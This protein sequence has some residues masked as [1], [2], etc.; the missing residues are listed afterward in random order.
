M[1]G[2]IFQVPLVPQV[3]QVPQV[4]TVPTV[5]RVPSVPYVPNIGN[6][7]TF[8]NNVNELINLNSYDTKQYVN[9]YDDPTRYRSIAD[10]VRSQPLI[11][12]DSGLINVAEDFGSWFSDN[13]IRNIPII[14]GLL[15]DT[16]DGTVDTVQSLY[17]DIIAIPYVGDV[18]RY[19]E[20][21]TFRFFAGL[22]QRLWNYLDQNYINPTEGTNPFLNA[23][24]ALGKDLDFFTGAN[25]VKSLVIP[26][27]QGDFDIIGNVR[28]GMGSS[29]EGIKHYNWD[30]GIFLLDLALE[31]ISDPS[32][33]ITLGGKSLVID[34]LAE[35][36][37]ESVESVTKTAIQS[38]TGV[39]DEVAEGLVKQ[40][41][42]ATIKGK[43][44]KK[45]LARKISE[46]GLEEAYTEYYSLIIKDVINNTTSEEIS[47]ALARDMV[48]K[49]GQEGGQQ[50]IKLYAMRLALSGELGDTYQELVEQYIE[51]AAREQTRKMFTA[52]V[53]N[54]VYNKT[55]QRF[56]DKGVDIF[57]LVDK[58]NTLKKVTNET[59]PKY[60][61]MTNPLGL[62]G[63]G[64]KKY[65][66][67]FYK[68]LKEK[69]IKWRTGNMSAEDFVS[70]FYNY[71]DA[72]YKF[73]DGILIRSTPQETVVKA[74]E[75][76]MYRAIAQL[77]TT[78]QAKGITPMSLY[79]TYEKVLSKVLMQPKVKLGLV[80]SRMLVYNEFIKAIQ[81]SYNIIIDE[82]D[83]EML[84]NYLTTDVLPKNLKKPE[85]IQTAKAIKQILGMLA[86]MKVVARLET[87]QTKESLTR[88]FRLLEREL[89]KYSNNYERLKRIRTGFFKY[90][91][92]KYHKLQNYR[93]I[94]KSVYS[95]E[96]AEVAIQEF[97][98]L[99]MH[100]GI[101]K[102]DL[103]KYDLLLDIYT[104][105]Q[106]KIEQYFKAITTSEKE[107]I[108]ARFGNHTRRIMRDA[109]TPVFADAFK[110][111]K[112]KYLREPKQIQIP[113]LHVDLQQFDENMQKIQWLLTKPEGT[114]QNRKLYV[115]MDIMH[116][117]PF[118]LDNRK[119]YVEV[120]KER[121]NVIDNINKNIDDFFDNLN[122]DYVL[123][124]V[125]D[126]K[127]IYIDK[128]K[129]INK[130]VEN[131]IEII[132]AFEEV[133]INDLYKNMYLKIHDGGYYP[134]FGLNDMV[135]ITRV[136]ED[137]DTVITEIYNSAI[138]Y[139]ENNFKIPL[140]EEYTPGAYKAPSKKL[141]DANGRFRKEKVW[142]MLDSGNNDEIA[143]AG[144]KRVEN[145][146][147]PVYSDDD[148]K[149]I[150]ELYDL[151]KE[152]TNL[153]LGNEF[154]LLINTTDVVYSFMLPIR[155]NYNLYIQN[156]FGSEYINN[157][158]KMLVDDKSQLRIALK[159]LTD[160]L[161][162]KDVRSDITERAA[163]I[164]QGLID[165]TKGAYNY[166][167]F[168]SNLSMYY[169]DI[170]DLK[171]QNKY[172]KIDMQRLINTAMNELLNQIFSGDYS[173]ELA[174]LITDK[175]KQD[176]MSHVH[177]LFYYPDGKL[178][179]ENLKIIGILK[180]EPFAPKIEKYYD[181]INEVIE[182]VLNCTSNALNAYVDMQTKSHS[183]LFKFF[184]KEMLLQVKE[185]EASYE[186]LNNVTTVYFNLK[187]PEVLY[188]FK[189]F[190]NIFSVHDL[191]DIN[192]DELELAFDEDVLE[193]FEPLKNIRDNSLLR[194]WIDTS[195][196]IKK[197][198]DSYLQEYGVATKAGFDSTFGNAYLANAAL[199]IGTKKVDDTAAQYFSE[200]FT[201]NFGLP[202]IYY[203]KLQDDFYK[204]ISK[205]KRF[206][207]TPEN[208]LAFKLFLIQ[209]TDDRVFRKVI[210]NGIDAGIEK[211]IELIKNKPSE[212]LRA[213][214]YVIKNNENFN[215]I[216]ANLDNLSD[217]LDTILNSITEK[218]LEQLDDRAIYKMRKALTG[219]SNNIGF[220]RFATNNNTILKFMTAR[221]L[222]QNTIE[223]LAEFFNE[224]PTLFTQQINR[225][226]L[227]GMP[228]AKQFV[229][230]K[231]IEK[232]P[233]TYLLGL[234]TVAYNNTELYEI[235]KNNNKEEFAKGK[236]ADYKTLPRIQNEDTLE[237]VKELV[238]AD[239]LHLAIANAKEDLY[240]DRVFTRKTTLLNENISYKQLKKEF[241][242]TL[243]I[244]E[245]EYNKLAKS[246]ELK[247]AARSNDLT[248]DKVNDIVTKLETYN[249][250]DVTK[251]LI[252][253]IKHRLDFVLGLSYI[254]DKGVLH[255]E[256]LRDFITGPN[257]GLIR[258]QT[259]ERKIPWTKKELNKVNLDI[260]TK[261]GVT[262]I[263]N[264]NPNVSE[265]F[266][267]SQKYKKYKSLKPEKYLDIY[268]DLTDFYNMF[269]PYTNL[270]DA[271]FELEYFLPITL[272]RSMYDTYVDQLAE[273]GIQNAYL[274][275]NFFHNDNARIDYVN[276][277]DPSF[278]A[279][280]EYG[281]KLTNL[282][283]YNCAALIKRAD[284]SINMIDQLFT[285]ECFFPSFYAVTIGAL[286]DEEAEYVLS[287][288]NYTGVVITTATKGAVVRLGTETIPIQT[289]KDIQYLCDL[290][291]PSAIVPTSL[292]YNINERI[293]NG[294][295]DS[296]FLKGLKLYNNVLKIG[297]LANPGF[298]FRDGVDIFFKNMLMTKRSF[299]EF[300]PYI[301]KATNMLDT[302]SKIYDEAI[303]LY[304]SPNDNH[305][306]AA[307]EAMAKSLG[308]KKNS[309]AYKDFKAEMN[310]VKELIES[311]T[312]DSPVTSLKKIQQEYTL[313]NATGFD[314]FLQICYKYL[315]NAP[316]VKQ[317]NAM[318]TYLENT[319]ARTALPLM[320]LEDTGSLKT[321]VEETA[322]THF[323]YG[324][325]SDTMKKV[326][327]LI[328]FCTFPMKN[329][330]FY[331]DHAMAYPVLIKTLLHAIRSS[332]S[333]ES[334]SYGKTITVDKDGHLKVDPF[335]LNIVKNGGIKLGDY[336]LKTGSSFL[337]AMSLMLDP[338]GELESRLTPAVRFGL[339][340]GTDLYSGMSMLPFGSE[341][342][343]LNKSI[344]QINKG[345][346]GL[347]TIAPSIFNKQ[348][349]NWY[350]LANVN[351]KNRTPRLYYNYPKSNR[352]P[353]RYGKYPKISYKA[354]HG[355]NRT[356]A[357]KRY[358]G[359]ISYHN[360]YYDLYKKNKYAIVNL[361]KWQAQNPSYY[362]GNAKNIVSNVNRIKAMFR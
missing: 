4:P 136:V 100:M 336:M 335:K 7:G 354:M 116:V 314:K 56:I 43:I 141:R 205:T 39:S 74:A 264:T 246:N 47:R 293:N 342:Y 172:Y 94:L 40:L 8:N 72:V 235:I 329:F 57:S 101:A 91:N 181:E 175:K 196:S 220:V 122:V 142:E 323:K 33:W 316:Y 238:S 99:L 216:T 184:D 317:L 55:A 320:L 331:L 210:N 355:S 202:S 259:R 351:L 155:D 272:K 149:I 174:M 348:T 82:T 301:K 140:T 13:I 206:K 88:S 61:Y 130:H 128:S 276:F 125:S 117:D 108:V 9:P 153:D 292:V 17:D 80:D 144:I 230:R 76:V 269:M 161:I 147:A 115:T 124:M 192:Y 169:E 225:Q 312:L 273:F 111:R 171:L 299:T 200:S 344:G 257:L 112:L 67:S 212:E 213:W 183:T 278:F 242:S 218:D 152:L 11:H 326:E 160:F 127:R 194:A 18:V 22:P 207:Y 60:V 221:V 296:N 64:V 34:P 118:D 224:D 32:N 154:K 310:I 319:V 46:E 343:K 267:D 45:N 97:E 2:N 241:H 83:Q 288:L 69:V 298:T 35:L 139:Q 42:E 98:R 123:N 223:K 179:A 315:Q 356:V 178:D 346:F 303:R 260:Y 90:S 304:G 151:S 352:S 256:D 176:I 231:Y 361:K 53:S 287:N 26:V 341:I 328:P 251:T 286:S 349:P 66:S 85:L 198:N 52:G 28:K 340:G 359:K 279:E 211:T 191:K 120:A 237:S 302:Y 148:F 249:K 170:K 182:A 23:L 167:L 197:I 165:S 280:Q 87:E 135:E 284:N 271:P 330:V 113:L 51:T 190:L 289:K 270:V 232:L 185:L 168:A 239:F 31:I 308:L 6:L 203:R 24:N 93:R 20:D 188:A 253:T 313:R 204:S 243:N 41:P 19:A 199:G 214:F 29:E 12:K 37:S 189:R 1:Y 294:V 104:K 306:E 109:N 250:Q 173:D 107:A 309:R 163:E 114:I 96:L 145:K 164:I 245:E 36:G 277:M 21:Y 27:T 281:L 338:L 208:E 324:G 321:A 332:W 156:I 285:Q 236:A 345:K 275:D 240:T 262:Y 228:K 38:L 327:L 137:F 70:E 360:I 133:F 353:I 138:K 358:Y 150:E 311:G 339:S 201:K 325:K 157:A 217:S 63:L 71:S 362:Y 81:T 44:L 193:T 15:E 102:Q 357:F 219:L 119:V 10:V 254:D 248:L 347:Q 187:Q 59:I 50:F 258:I 222:N 177:N 143:A 159:Y 129:V 25:I 255:L 126:L 158:I 132:D 337:D 77:P 121:S 49:F 65:G 233:D 318:T 307:M 92:N 131:N 86:D 68:Y 146:K 229:F 283:T 95:P 261:D 48:E 266:N 3:P 103:F 166:G 282:L 75:P 322:T 106:D 54:I 62:T 180:K 297:M 14:G 58:V 79:K 195:N 209:K 16:I 300:Y 265:I 5:P 30:T 350:S 334:G 290:E 263:Y 244:T 134:E 268:K 215:K 186:E 78:W 291:A 227:N 162:S 295:T 247:D 333:D 274:N 226:A 110:P 105:D 89:N 234:Y 84:L 73:K 252:Y 305:L